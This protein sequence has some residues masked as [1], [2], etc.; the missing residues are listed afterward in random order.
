MKTVYEKIIENSFS[1]QIVV[2]NLIRSAYS[3]RQISQIN[4]GKNNPEVLKIG[5]IVRL[6]LNFLRILEISKRSSIKVFT[7]NKN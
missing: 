7:E 4:R 3:S 6:M 1:H 2:Y 5:L